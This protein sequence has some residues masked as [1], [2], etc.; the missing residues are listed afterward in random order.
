MISKIKL[1]SLPVFIETL[2]LIVFL[3]NINKPAGII[4]FLVFLAIF[5]LMAVLRR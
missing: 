1:L 5:I 2:I 3:C 4:L